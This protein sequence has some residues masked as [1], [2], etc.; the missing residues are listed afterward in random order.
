MLMSCFHILR[1]IGNL[2]PIYIVHVMRD[3]ICESCYH[4]PR[5]FPS[6]S[7]YNSLL[8]VHSLQIVDVWSELR[9][10]SL[11]NT[12]NIYSLFWSR[13]HEFLCRLSQIV[14]VRIFKA[15]PHSNWVFNLTPLGR[16]HPRH[17]RYIDHVIITVSI[18]PCHF[19]PLYHGIHSFILQ[20]VFR[21]F[22]C[23]F[24]SKFSTECDLVLPR[25]ISSIP[26]VP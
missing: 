15:W 8:T 25:S 5:P 18:K 1:S 24:Q 16:E 26:S 19:N 20:S 12:R 11:N 21:H 2:D 22:H 10:V 13:R 9:T 4:W 7:Y 23:L 6:T 17:L 3:Y 14:A